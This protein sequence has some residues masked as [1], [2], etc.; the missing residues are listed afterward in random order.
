MAASRTGRGRGGDGTTQG[1]ETILRRC[2]ERGMRMTVQR[3]AVLASLVSLPDHPSAD[4]VFISVAA[5]LPGVSRTTIYRTLEQLV[6]V[7]VI[8]KACHPGSTARY[9]SRVDL[10]HHLVCLQCD[11]MIDITD[12]RLDR[13]PVPD[14]SE[15][16]FEVSD[17]RVQL[18]GLCRRCS[19]KRRKE[20]SE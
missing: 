1:L 13:L 10:H 7:G 15:F 18:R 4:D 16:G 5:R 6:R 8:G 3:R 19:R 12:A 17:F 11:A 14:T 2:R 20:D 9:D